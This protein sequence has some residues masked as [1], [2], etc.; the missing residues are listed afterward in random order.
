ME[1]RN[2]T[3]TPP[4]L[5]VFEL[6]FLGAEWPK[7]TTNSPGEQQIFINVI[8]ILVTCFVKLQFL[9]DGALNAVN[10]IT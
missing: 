3:Q 9:L 4:E 10:Y 5:N 6:R 8:E 2:N 7:K 1:K